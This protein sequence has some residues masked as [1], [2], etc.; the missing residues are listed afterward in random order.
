MEISTAA[1]HRARG[2]VVVQ[3]VAGLDRRAGFPPAPVIMDGKYEEGIGG[4][5]SQV[6]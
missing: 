4:G 1:F 3:R 2:D 5:V 6:A